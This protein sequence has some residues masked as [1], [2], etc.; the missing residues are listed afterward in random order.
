MIAFDHTLRITFAVTSAQ[1]VRLN[2]SREGRRSTNS[3]PAPPPRRPPPHPA[4]PPAG[5]GGCA[6]ARP[7]RPLPA[8]AP[9]VAGAAGGDGQLDAG[10]HEAADRGP[11]HVVLGD[12]KPRLP[13]DA[14]E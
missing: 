1:R 10:H 6:A 13:R 11:R 7:A 3:P 8:R 12:L 5:R 9:G 2:G 4:A 14:L